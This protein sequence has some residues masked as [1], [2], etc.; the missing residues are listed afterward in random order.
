MDPNN[1]LW[2]GGRF[3]RR[4]FGLSQKTLAKQRLRRELL[5]R[6]PVVSGGAMGFWACMD[7]PIVITR[8][9]SLRPSFCI[10]APGSPNLS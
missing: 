3:C 10:V 4:P 1:D 6:R 2:K 7:M 8:H 9:G 5:A